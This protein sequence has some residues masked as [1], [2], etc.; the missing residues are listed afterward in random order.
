MIGK[1]LMDNLSEKYDFSW[2]LVKPGNYFKLS[3][4]SWFVMSP[5][6]ESG[7]VSEPMWKIIEHEDGT[8]TVF[9]SIFFDSPN[10]WHGF[11]ERGVWRQV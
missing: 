8:I 4:G 2:A 3:D 7:R 10:G 9:P 1:R 5:S 11:L 6:G